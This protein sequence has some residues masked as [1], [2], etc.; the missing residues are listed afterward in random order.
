[1]FPI[2]VPISRLDAAAAVAGAPAIYHLQA[3]SPSQQFWKE[4][5]KYKYMCN[6]C[7]Y[8]CNKYKYKY[9]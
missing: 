2:D 7:K 3:L 4:I 1:M 5:L 6:K 8:M 9:K